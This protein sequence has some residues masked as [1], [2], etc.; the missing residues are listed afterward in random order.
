MQKIERVSVSP[1]SS[2]DVRKWSLGISRNVKG[3]Y[4]TRGR[5]KKIVASETIRGVNIASKSLEQKR[6]RK[7]SEKSTFVG[8]DQKTEN[9]RK[10]VY[11]SRCK[12]CN[13]PHGV[14]R[15]EK[16]KAMSIQERWDAA[17]R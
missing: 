6:N 8:R 12:V 2:L 7:D 13:G 14:W 5:I 15:C 3:V 11:M 17:K 9:H 4:R 16:F 10:T 1:L